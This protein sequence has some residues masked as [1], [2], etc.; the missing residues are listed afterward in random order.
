MNPVAR[1]SASLALTLAIWGP[2][3]VAAWRR[4]PDV[5]GHSALRFLVIFTLVRFALRAIDALI[6]S[7][8][9]ASWSDRQRTE[10]IDRPGVDPV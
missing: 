8:L 7:Y 5:L 4:G 10:T 2:N 1:I 9:R 6:R 3:T